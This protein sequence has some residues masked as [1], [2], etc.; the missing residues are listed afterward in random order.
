LTVT[1]IGE[2]KGEKKEHHSAREREGYSRGKDRER[3]IEKK[4][5][6]VFAL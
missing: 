2:E 6:R 1:P 3:S 4:A 5:R